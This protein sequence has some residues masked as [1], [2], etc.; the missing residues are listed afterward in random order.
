[1]KKDKYEKLYEYA[2]GLKDSDFTER[3]YHCSAWFTG[4]DNPHYVFLKSY[5][6]VVAVF[7]RDEKTVVAFGRYSMTTYQHVR[8]FRNRMWE[9]WCNARECA[10]RDIKEVNMEKENWFH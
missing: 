8:K 7:D 4:G 1:M 2:Q 5:N 3:L 10:A 9:L 6:T